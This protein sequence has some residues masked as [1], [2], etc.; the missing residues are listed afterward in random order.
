MTTP[1]DFLVIYLCVLAAIVACRVLPMF[2]LKGRTLS[3]RVEEAFS[4]IPV[5]AFAAL[6]A[7]D[8][9]KPDAFA[10]DPIQGLMPLVAALPVVV[11]AKKTGSLI[12]SAVVGMAVYALLVYV[13]M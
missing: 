6:V 4:L 2:L 1:Q 7:N 12:W 8:L 13:I 3:P 11:V 5:A 10:N 9:L